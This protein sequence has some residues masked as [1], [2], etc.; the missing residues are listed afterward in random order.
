MKFNRDT[1]E[2]KEKVLKALMGMSLGQKASKEA[3]RLAKKHV[4][5]KKAE[6]IIK[7]WETLREER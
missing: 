1:E 4:Y 2:F 3:L 5:K 7:K 6:T